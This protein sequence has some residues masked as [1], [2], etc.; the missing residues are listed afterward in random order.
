MTGPVSRRRLEQFEPPFRA[1]LQ[2]LDAPGH[3]GGFGV[4]PGVADG[5][6]VLPPRRRRAIRAGSGG[7]QGEVADPRVEVED[8]LGL[9]PEAADEPR[10]LL[11]ELYVHLRV[12]L[13]EGLVAR[14]EDEIADA[15][16]DGLFAE[17][18]P[19]PS[20]ADAGDD[21]GGRPIRPS[22]WCRR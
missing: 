16:A 4:C 12:R 15:V 1:L 14:L 5:G 10:H 21:V 7:G 8:A 11:D 17:D 3:S 20:L 2:E 13:R 18:D 6:R 22:A 19:L 9:G